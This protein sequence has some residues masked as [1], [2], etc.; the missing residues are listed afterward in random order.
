MPDTGLAYSDRNQER[1]GD[2]TSRGGSEPGTPPKT[3]GVP[4][5]PLRGPPLRVEALELCPGC[6][7]GGCEISQPS[8]EI[9]NKG[10]LPWELW[11]K[12]ASLGPASSGLFGPSGAC[13]H[14]GSGQAAASALDSGLVSPGSPRPGSHPAWL[15]GFLLPRPVPPPPPRVRPRRVAARG[16]E[17]EPPGGEGADSRQPPH[18]CC[19]RPLPRSPPS[20]EAPYCDLPRC[21]PAPED[22]LST[23]AFARLPVV[24][25][26]LS[27]GPE[28]GSLPTAEPP[29]EESPAVPRS[30]H[31]DLEVAPCPE[32]QGSSC[33]SS[34]EDP[35]PDTS[36]GPDSNTPDDTSNS[37]PVVQGDGSGDR[38][39]GRVTSH[40]QLPKASQV[41]EAQDIGRGVHSNT[42]WALGDGVQRT[43]QLLCAEGTQLSDTGGGR[44]SAGQHWAKLR[45]ESSYFSLERPRSTLAHASSATLQSR[46]RGATRQA[47]CAQ[48]TSTQRD[49]LRAS[50]PPRLTQKDNSRTSAAQQDSPTAPSVQQ[51]STP[52]TSSPLRS[53]QQNNPRTSSPQRNNPQL[54]SPL[55]APQQDNLQTSFSTCIP[56]RESSRTSCAQRDN[57]R[58]SSPNRTTQRE[59]SRTSCAQQDNARISP[60]NRTAQQD[61][62][63]ISPS[64]RTAQQ[65]SARISPSNRTAQQDSARTSCAQRDNPRASSP[66]R[67]AQWDNPR[68][69]C[70][71]Q[72]APR[73]SSA[74]RDNPKTSRSK[75]EHLRS[76]GAKRD[77]PHCSTLQRG[78][79]GASSS[80]SCLPGD[81]PGPPSPHRTTPR[82]SARHPSPHR[83]NKDIPWASFPLRPT[84]SDGPRAASP[85]RS[86][87]SEV[88][89][90]SIALR[91]TQGDRP[92]ASSPAR[93][94]Q[95][96]TLQPSCGSTQ[97]RPASQAA[98]SCHHQGQPSACPGSSA[99][100]PGP[101][102]APQTSWEPSQPPFAVCIGHRDA[103]RASSPPRYV[104]HDPFP[105][106]PDPRPSESEAPHHDPP[107][108]PPAVCIGHRDAPRASSPPRYTQFDPF[109]FLPEASDDA[110]SE[111][112]QHDPPRFPP[113]V[114][115]G[116]R[117]APRASSPPRQFPEPSLLQDLPRAS[118][119]SLVQSTDSLHELPSFPTPVCIGHRDA[120]SFSSPPRHAP[121]PSLLFQDPPGTSMESLAP[122][123]D[124]LHGSPLPT[125]QVCIGHRDAPRA[126]SPPRHPP[127]DL[128]FLASS[129][130]PGSSGGS[131]GSAPPG[132]TR[133][134]LERE[135]YTVLADLPPPRRLAQR[136]PGP[137]AQGSNGGRTRSPGRAEV[138]RLFGQ[139]RRKS[140][141]PGAFQARD[142][143]RSQRPSQSQSQLVRRQSSPAPS[144]QVTKPPAKQ[145]ELARRSQAEPPHPRSPE[146][147]PQGTSPPPRMSARPRER[148]PRPERR[149][150]R[151]PGG[152]RRPGGRWQSQEE[153]PASRR[154]PRSLEEED[155]GPGP[156][157]G[158]GEPSLGAAGAL[159]EARRGP[160]RDYQES[161]GQ[162]EAWEE[163]SRNGLQGPPQRSWG[164]LQELSSLPQPVS[165]PD[166]HASWGGVTDSVHAQQPETPTAMG[167]ERQPDLDWRDLLGLFRAP[168][169]GAWARLPRLDWDGLLELLQA[170]LPRRDPAGHWG[171]PAKASEPE[172]G[173]PDTKDAPEQKQQSQPESLAN[174]DRPRQPPQIPAQPPIPA[175]TSTQWPK[176]QVTS[177]PETS[178]LA[179]L[180]PTGQREP[181]SPAEGSRPL[182]REVQPEEPEASE[183]SQGQ[184]SSSDQEQADSTSSPSASRDVRSERR[185]WETAWVGWAV[186]V[187]LPPGLPFEKPGTS[188]GFCRTAGSPKV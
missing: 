79:P 123:T 101:R 33:G 16:L 38:E 57:S 170:R 87:Q 122:S 112:P 59:H 152:P 188:R 111:A 113:P 90:A 105:F 32:G 64:N 134:N 166:S 20:A 17:P 140:E 15:S 157:P 69:S 94:A 133:H 67:T 80:Q 102:A 155:L 147:R 26:G 144:R 45:R 72:N 180:E 161:W 2:P 85:S 25:L 141:T 61:S 51:R 1:G 98:S 13:A 107:Y 8:A 182:E 56:Q 82:S 95:R 30:R 121:E 172:L 58:T 40:L 47:P 132:E 37:S 175:Y 62:A 181:H 179:D 71:Q 65:D 143:G 54:S 10:L 178:P 22:L 129:P 7:R 78:N 24:G 77:T 9:G 154:P 164:S 131:R 60:S 48:A 23:A 53:S 138:E 99:G 145:A 75:W 137:P 130:P 174:R 84:Q 115:I 55:R 119:E 28:R 29:D 135:E 153:L 139:E 126:S 114:C 128:A 103:P 171:D 186:L 125:P 44:H 100:C 104:Q 92:Q 49:P 173:P 34:D 63:R 150:E 88:P 97:H 35:T 39:P 18:H 158:G 91:P 81:N 117:D 167:P 106:F 70:T 31:G 11:W 86:K 108:M 184:D 159:E 41:S 6:P 160:P 5:L 169:E 43:T 127:G 142:E 163:P 76:A 187:L 93:S 118:T 73:A 42:G 109:P 3:Q 89:W 149:L 96:D 136:E 165:P 120:P 50:S 14:L 19:W 68:T 52:R 148:E 185:N 156:W 124:S 27:Q 74:H 4:P 176:T 177:G 21:P 183:P 66:N 83:T 46:P 162:P 12:V 146:R 168:G 110:G 116:H 36:S 151:D